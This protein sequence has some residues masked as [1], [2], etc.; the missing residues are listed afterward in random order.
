MDATRCEGHNRCLMF[1][2][3]VFEADDMGYVSA[4]GDGSV[5]P[6]QREAVWLASVNCPEEAISVVTEDGDSEAGGS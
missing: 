5:P 2:T 4:R 3:D 1:D 6:E